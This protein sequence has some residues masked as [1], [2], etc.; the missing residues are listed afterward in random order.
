VRAAERTRCWMVYIDEP[1]DRQRLGDATVAAH[2]RQGADPAFVLER[3]RWT[4]HHDADDLER[5]RDDRRNATFAVVATLADGRRSHLQAG[6]AMQEVLLTGTALGL[7][8]SIM[9]SVL[10]VPDLRGEVRAVLGGGLWPQAVLRLG[11]AVTRSAPVR[12][13]ATT[14]E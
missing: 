8:A 2:G 5:P 6:R 3:D 10:E 13:L 12:R 9:P 4:G 1:D 11:H 14:R 7:S